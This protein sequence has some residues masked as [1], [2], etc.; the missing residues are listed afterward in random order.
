MQQLAAAIRGH[1]ESLVDQYDARLCTM[2]GYS[3]LPETMRRELECHVLDLISQCLEAADYSTLV[4]YVQERASQWVAMDLDLAWFQQALIVPEDI[5]VPLIESAEAST[6]LWRALNRSQGAVWQL[7]AERAHTAEQ[8]LQ[9]NQQLLQTVMDNIPQAIFW[10]DKHLVYL[11]CNRAFAADAGLTSPSDVIGRTDWEMPWQA[12]AELYRADDSLVL[13]NGTPKLDY[14]EPQTTPDGSTIWLRTSKVPMRDTAGNMTAVLGMYEDITER[15]RTEAA[16][17]ESQQ[18]FQGLVET[19]SDWIWEVDQNGVYTYVSPKVKDLLG[20][21]PQEVLG[22]TPFDL[23]PPE[24]AQRVAAIFGPLLSARQ[25]LVALE[26]TNRHKDGRLVVFETSGVP[27]FDADGQFKGY[28]GTDRDITQRKQTELALNQLLAQHST[29]L[30]NALVGIAHLVDRKFVWMNSKMTDMFGYTP[31]EVAGISTAALYPT[32]QDFEQLGRDAYPLLSQGKTYSTERLMRRKDGSLFWCAIAGKSVPGGQVPGSIWILQDITE[33]KRAEETLRE[34]EAKYSAVVT[35]ATDGVVIIQDNI[36]KFVNQSLTNTLGYATPAEIE[37]T[38]FIR[39]LAPDSVALVVERVKARLAGK[40]VPAVYEA[41]LRRKDGSVFDAEL[42]AGVIQYLGKPADLG[43]IR[44]IT[45]RKRA[46]EALRTSQQLLQTVMDNIPQAIFWKDRNLTYLGCNRAFAADAG[47][48]SPTDAFGKT[49]WDMPWQA[50]AELYRADDNLVMESGT[51]KLDY[52]EPQ[53]TPDGSTI[54][55]RTS[56]VP[57]RDT[58]GNVTAVLGMYEDITERKRA[59]AAVRESQQRLSLLVQQSP[60]AVIE[61]NTDY[62]VVEWNPA[63][64]QIFGYTREEVLGHY[65]AGFLVPEKARQ[66]ASQTWQTLLAQKGTAHG[67]SKN[68]TKDGRLI[69]CDWY[70]TP[71]VG[72]DGKVIG[73]A[74]LVQDITERR[75]LER[76]IQESLKRRG[77]QVQTS[78]EVSQ[79]IATAPDLDELFRRVVTLIKERFNYY[80]S[81]IFRYEPSLDAVVLVTGYGEVG[82]HMLTE[83]HKLPMGRGVVGTAAASGDSILAPD[84]AQDEDWRPNPYLPDTQGELAV[85]I[86]FQDQVLGILDVQSDQAGRLSED[87]RLLLEGLCGQIASAMESTRLLEELRSS[88]AQLSEALKIAKLA[89]WEYDVEK[90]LFIFNDQF[91][92]I[93][94]TTVEQHGGY[95][96]S[97]AYYAQH[98]VHPDDLALVGAEIEKA[99]KSTDRHYNRLLEHRIQYADGGVGHIT[100]NVNIDRDEQGHILRYYGANQDITERKLAEEALRQSEAQLSEALRIAHLA[101]WEYDVEHDLFQ[102]NDHFYA[103]FHTTAEAEGGYQMSSARYAQKFVH[104]DDAALVGLEIGRALASTDRRYTRQLEHRILY[105]D[106]GVGHISV[107]LTIERDEHGHILRYYGANEDITER[108]VAELERERARQQME[109]AMHEAQRL[110]TAVSREG[111]QDYRQVGKLPN[112]YRFDRALIEP[113]PDTWL[114]ELGQAVARHELVTSQSG[115]QPAAVT[116]LEIRGEIIGAL[117][118][119]DDPAH[120]MQADDLALV[121][122]VSEQV[123]LALESARLFDQTQRD[124]EREHSLNR[125]ATALSRSSSVKELL[126]IVLEITLD[127]LGFECGVATL[128][129]TETNTLRILAQRDLPEQLA[130]RLESSLVGT[131]CEYVFVQGQ[132]TF[133]E[134]VRQ[135]APVDVS[136][137]IAQG[138]LSY[139][140][141]PL[142][143]Q[144]RTLGTLCMFSHTPKRLPEKIDVLL[145]SIGQQIGVGVAN[146]RLFEQT[147]RDAERERTIAAISERIYS[148]TNVEDLLRI[149][150]EELRRATGSARAVVKLGR[151]GLQSDGSMIQPATSDEGVTR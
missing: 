20:Y 96:L 110:Y 42:S 119:V 120:P 107:R 9:Q 67:T 1:A 21:E 74:S 49:D 57:M 86:K 4:R 138:L 136:G 118:V 25:P 62:E 68:L 41:Q 129:D 145:N 84:V 79:E 77:Q 111:W 141:I 47:L 40:E 88:E 38:P 11:G 123:A 124:T 27:F 26:N 19:L 70:N 98:F 31:E 82:Q 81:Q 95:Q 22:K 60:L 126:P 127:V 100:V 105:A 53:T 17:R 3:R 89:Y 13:E 33:R 39:Y 29:V 102:F 37:N 2:P 59:E 10:K 104:P 122:A 130:K 128:S 132:A 51:P 7:I 5:L 55:L 85:P 115:H 139:V 71:L 18:R 73:V 116:P 135:G 16:V 97:S 66:Q 94:H 109:E 133:L 147:Q 28:R 46:E 50:Q 36:I 131:L 108:K 150:A 91:Y 75:Q 69:T 134:D 48:T 148:T 72:V 83:G 112:G 6:F 143:Y 101:Y 114:P 90:D 52:E 121:K 76:Q 44:D 78:T 142:R 65:T 14:E 144:D 99:L 63:A 23:M 106:G 64:E 34:S 24:E 45:E 125:I 43:L 61:W 117:G 87:D 113:A 103:I 30:E 56:K 151:V 140:G 149:T 80:H 35:Q 32:P 58:H 15:K 137:L 54:W 92:S 146:A 93:F 8:A 12:Q